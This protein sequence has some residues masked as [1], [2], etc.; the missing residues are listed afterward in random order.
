MERVGGKEAGRQ[1]GRQ[2]GRGGGREGGIGPA[3]CACGVRECVCAACLCV[4]VSVD[5]EE[6][7]EAGEG[8]GGGEDR[9]W[10]RRRDPHGWTADSQTGPCRA[11]RA[12]AG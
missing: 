8:E 7:R 12:P 10:W 6:E 5:E 9:R 3:V 4:H 2:G 11:R 1:V